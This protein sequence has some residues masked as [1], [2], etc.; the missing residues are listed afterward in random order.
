MNDIPERDWKIIRSMKDQKLTIACNRI[1]EKVTTIIKDGTKGSVARYREL[2]KI[3]RNEDDTIGTM[4]DDLKRSNAIMKLASWQ[5][6]ELV[7]DEEMKTFT[8]ETQKMVTAINRIDD[9]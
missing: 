1:L 9:E 2:W 8:A 3:L 4:F 6:H 7:S 5:Y